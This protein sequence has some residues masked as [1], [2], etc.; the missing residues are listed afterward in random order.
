LAT[1]FTAGID[2][3]SRAVANMIRSRDIFLSSSLLVNVV[4]S[5]VALE[6][7]EVQA[8]ANPLCI[9]AV[10]FAARALKCTWMHSMC[11][12]WP[13]DSG[14]QTDTPTDLL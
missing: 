3:A 8:A 2:S 1:R 9:E 14:A 7:R 12:L 4:I 5:N 11:E 13:V 6:L 10:A